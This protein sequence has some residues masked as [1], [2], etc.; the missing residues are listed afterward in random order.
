M[1]YTLCIEYSRI[2]HTFLAVVRTPPPPPQLTAHVEIMAIS[3]SSLLVFSFYMCSGWRFCLQLLQWGGG[4]NKG[5]ASS[6][7]LFHAVPQPFLAPKMPPMANMRR[8]VTLTAL[9]GEN[10]QYV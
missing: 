1:L 4:G 10:I 6:Y 8:S 9:Y 5:W 2:T 3:V 7:V